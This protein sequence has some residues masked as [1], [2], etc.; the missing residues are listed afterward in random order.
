MDHGTQYWPTESYKLSNSMFCLFFPDGLQWYRD[1][2][3]W[4][5]M[6]GTCLLVDR[7]SCQ[8]SRMLQSVNCVL[9]VLFV[10][11]FGW[12]FFQIVMLFCLVC[13]LFSD[14]ATAHWALS[15]SG[16]VCHLPVS[17]YSHWSA[18]SSI[19]VCKPSGCTCTM[20]SSN[21]VFSFSKYFRSEQKP[22]CHFFEYYVD[23]SIVLAHS[24]IF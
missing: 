13:L 1:F 6:A 15:K 21:I 14:V 12:L 22:Q 18:Q 20:T 3:I 4:S 7:L 23:C 5:L 8:K 17:S 16:G 19:R 11:V 24:F 10:G 9:C 2:T